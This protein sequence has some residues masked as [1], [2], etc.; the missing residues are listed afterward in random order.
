VAPDATAV[1]PRDP[2]FELRMIANWRPG[3]PDGDRHRAWVRRGWADLRPYSA[4]QFASFLSDEGPAGVRA[5]YGDR[6]GRLTAL[7]NRY[8]PA[9]VLALN[10]NIPPTDLLTEENR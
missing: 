7:K 9:N 3:D 6:L 1:G 4:G 2:G 5:A 8:D 10:P